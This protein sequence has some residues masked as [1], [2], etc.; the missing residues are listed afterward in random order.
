[1]KARKRNV[2]NQNCSF[3]AGQREVVEH[4]IV[5]YGKYESHRKDLINVLVSVIRE[6]EWN[7]R[8]N[9]D[10]SGISTALS[11]YETNAHERI[12]E[13]MKWFLMK[14]SEMRQG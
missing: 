2:E 7:R 14:S 11:L 10:D 13:A 4:F 6:E 8:M 1:M 9:E 5:E 3:C 12:M